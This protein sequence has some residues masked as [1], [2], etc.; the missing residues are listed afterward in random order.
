MR[1]TGARCTKQFLLYW[2]HLSTWWSPSGD[3]IIESP[4]LA[5]RRWW[6]HQRSTVFHCEKRSSPT[7]GFCWAE[8]HL[9]TT[10]STPMT[11]DQGN[12]GQGHHRRAI[13]AQSSDHWSP[14]GRDQFGTIGFKSSRFLVFSVVRGSSRQFGVVWRNP[15]FKLS[16]HPNM[17]KI[18][19]Y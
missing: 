11:W 1:G 4:S 9:V 6:C 12:T 13:P 7:K 19:K 14:E 10:S 8:Y 16:S 18:H 2:I 3:P 5:V 17:S 15:K